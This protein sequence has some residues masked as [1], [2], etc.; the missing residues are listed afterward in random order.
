MPV[1]QFQIHVLVADVVD[2]SNLTQEQNEQLLQA[3][4]GYTL[5]IKNVSQFKK[6][7]PFLTPSQSKTICNLIRDNFDV[8]VALK[9]AIYSLV[10]ERGTHNLPYAARRFKEFG[11]PGS[12]SFLYHKLVA[13]GM[14][15]TVRKLLR[16]HKVKIV[17]HPDQVRQVCDAIVSD[18]KIIA[19]VKKFVWAKLRAFAEASLLIDSAASGHGRYRDFHNELLA[20]AVQ[21]LYYVMPL[22]SIAH[23]RNYMQRTIHNHGIL[24]IKFFTAQRRRRLVA[25]D[26]GFANRVRTMERKG[27]DGE[28]VVDPQVEIGESQKDETFRTVEL[29][30]SVDRVLKQSVGWRRRAIRLF[31]LKPNEEFVQFWN[32]QNRK[33][34]TSVD[35]V[36]H[37]LGNVDQY[38]EFV[39]RFLRIK[40]EVFY[41]WM[42]SLAEGEIGKGKTHGQKTSD[43]WAL[44]A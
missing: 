12:E 42:K 25:D 31:V 14:D 15:K 39:R 26:V 5:R 16:T 4:L 8:A 11:L 29:R 28:S 17:P 33:K 1:R 9:L 36:Y 6:T 32:E 10:K 24:M 43:S 21:S 41:N 3:V 23:A 30:L 38:I 13:W 40:A 2:V 19:F 44:A 34:L 20:K 35:D 37:Y 27:E 7:A 22:Y 18:P